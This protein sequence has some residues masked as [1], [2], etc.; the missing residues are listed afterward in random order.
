MRWFLLIDTIE[1]NPVGM[2][3]RPILSQ[4]PDVAGWASPIWLVAPHAT[5]GQMSFVMIILASAE[6]GG[7]TTYARCGA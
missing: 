3:R 4:K 1:R 5:P 7:V 6:S 2:A